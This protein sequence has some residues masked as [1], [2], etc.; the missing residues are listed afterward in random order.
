M[1]DELGWKIMAEFV[2]L[3]TK[4]KFLMDDGNNDKKSKGIKECVIKQILK[5]FNDYNNCLL[6]NEIILISQ[7]RFKSEVHNIY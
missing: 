2:A 4:N 3:K 7:Q 5:K 6:H 1:K